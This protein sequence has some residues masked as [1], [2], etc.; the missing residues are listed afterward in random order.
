M[1]GH[2]FSLLERTESI[3]AV[4]LVGDGLS[5]GRKGRQ[6]RRLTRVSVTDAG[7]C[8]KCGSGL[9]MCCGR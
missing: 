9:R 6:A 3:Y 8:T 2:T 5:H 1:L 4:I 7:L